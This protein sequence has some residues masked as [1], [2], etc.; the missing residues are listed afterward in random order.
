MGFVRVAD[1]SEQDI[2]LLQG[3]AEHHALLVVDVVVGGPVHHQVLLVGELLGLGVDVTG[4][5][6]SQVVV[7]CGQSQVPADGDIVKTT[8]DRVFCPLKCDGKLVVMKIS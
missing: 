6:A 2:G 4:L 8:F 1:L 3:S 5:V 7:R